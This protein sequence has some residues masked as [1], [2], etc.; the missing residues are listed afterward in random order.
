MQLLRRR[1]QNKFCD[2]L[3]HFGAETFNLEVCLISP[4]LLLKK[5]NVFILLLYILSS[6]EKVTLFIEQSLVVF[7]SWPGYS[8]LSSWKSIRFR[9]QA[10][11]LVAERPTKRLFTHPLLLYCIV[12]LFS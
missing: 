8:M 5:E 11:R 2:H 9:S 10:G 6:F 7:F 3:C 4:S 1:V 12:F